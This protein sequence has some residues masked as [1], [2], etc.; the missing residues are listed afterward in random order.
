MILVAGSANMDFITAVRQ[1]PAPGETVLGADYFT[2]PGGKGANQ[3]VACARAGAQVAFL[4]ALGS[5]WVADELRAALKESGVRD[6]TLAVPARTGAAFIGVSDA[7]ENS[8][9]VASGA[10]AHLR[11]KHLPSLQGIKTLILQLE[12]PLET[13]TAF[14]VQAHQEGV[15]VMLNAAPARAL[16]AELLRVIDTLIV[17]EVELAALAGTAGQ[18]AAEPLAEQLRAVQA[19][20]PGQVLVTLGGRGSLL[21]SGTELLQT[22]AYPV[23]VQDT[24]GAGDT[25]V[26]VLAAFLAEGHDWPDALR[27]ASVG[28]ALACTRA[29]A[30]PSMPGRTE[31]LAAAK[32]WQP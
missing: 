17:N 12:I 16:P 14:A 30:Q 4:G 2:A 13:V 21:L 23:Q 6:L 8:I 18:D 25:F 24:T 15:E 3:A 7:G 9:I 27:L 19:L 32:G 31:I 28:A 1:L 20:G 22:P 11:P 5:D 10:N 26:G 29:G